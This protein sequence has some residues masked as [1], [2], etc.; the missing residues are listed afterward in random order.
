MKKFEEY[1]GTDENVIVSEEYT[2]LGFFV[3]TQKEHVVSIQ[4]DALIE[5][6]PFTT[7]SGCK[8]L[9]NVTLPSTVKTIGEYAF[10]G[11]KKLQEIKLPPMVTKI[12]KSAFRSCSTLK[13]V[14]IPL[15]T[16]S[17]GIT[18]FKFCKGLE[19]AYISKTVKKI[20]KEAFAKCPDLTIVTTAGSVAEK[21]AE[22]EGIPVQLVSDADLETAIKNAWGVVEEDVISAPKISSATALPPCAP[23][24]H[25]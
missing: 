23:G 17:I 7:F 21:Y 4:I 13:E 15:T 11:C 9:K 18:A 5:E 10:E 24:Y 1:Q 25:A 16:K 14:A 19:R 8:N 20:G 2:H 6:I 12:D 3:F 22:G